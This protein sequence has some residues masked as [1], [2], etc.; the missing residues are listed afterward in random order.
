MAKTKRQRRHGTKAKRASGGR[1]AKNVFLMNPG[2]IS[3]LIKSLRGTAGAGTSR[4]RRK[5][6]GKKRTGTRR[7]HSTRSKFLRNP[8]IVSQARP[9]F[10]DVVGVVG[11]AVATRQLPQMLLGTANTGVQGYLANAA[12]IL[13]VY[14]VASVFGSKRVAKMAALGGGVYL[15]MRVLNE[16]FSPIGQALSLQG[17]GDAQACSAA[18]VSARADQMAQGGRMIAA[19]AYR[20]PEAQYT[21]RESVAVPMPTR[22]AYGRRALP[23]AA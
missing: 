19:P 2:M 13:A 17:L 21:T 10:G 16:K 7:K 9:F 20:T 4:P 14:V 12:A 5:A 8:G 11:G 23:M 18:L 1:A 6:T 22:G 3:N 15:F